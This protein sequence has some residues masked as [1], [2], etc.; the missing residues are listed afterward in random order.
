MKTLLR[1]AVIAAVCL[2]PLTAYSQR[3]SV[4]LGVSLLP[5]AF[6]ITSSSD[7]LY[8]PLGFTTF[9]IPV[10]VG[11]VLRFEPEFGYFSG[12]FESVTSVSSERKVGLARAGGGILYLFRSPAGFE[13]VR[14]YV[15]P[16]VALMPY[17]ERE[18]Y[19]SGPE[20]RT[21]R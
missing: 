5:N 12:A 8:Y 7:V 11:D 2:F 10:T 18:R 1:P 21:T 17:W 9:M 13:N 14:L 15:G 20:E 4:G 6:S 3:V 16:R 19:G